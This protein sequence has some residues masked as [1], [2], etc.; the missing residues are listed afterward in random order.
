MKWRP[1]EQPPATLPAPQIFNTPERR[2]FTL[3]EWGRHPAAL[4]VVQARQ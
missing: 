4:T 2:G 3:V 1:L